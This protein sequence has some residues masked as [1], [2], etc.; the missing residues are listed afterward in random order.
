MKYETVLP[1]DFDGVFKFT[2]YSEDEFIGK[3][4]GK[5][6]HYPATKTSPMI[7]PEHSPLEIQNIRKKFAKDLAEREFFKSKGYETLRGQEGTPGNRSMNSIHQAGTYSLDQL[8][9]FIQKALMP[10][11]KGTVVV[12]KAP[13]VRLEE[14]LSKNED[15]DLNTGAVKNDRDLE[16]L[17]KG[18]PTMEERVLG[19]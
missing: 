3:W 7:I 11:E 4:G 9:P 8:T 5:E 16:N 12:T 14:K 19:K 1:E 2:N 6:Y 18:K 13:T 17:A 10:L 15:G